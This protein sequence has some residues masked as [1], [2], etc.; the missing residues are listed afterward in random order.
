MEQY[1]IEYDT[2]AELVDKLISQKYPDQLPA[3][4]NEIR[5][6]EIQKL[7][8]K[9][10]VKIF[11][12]LNEQQLKEVNALLD[13]DGQD[14]SALKDFFA[15]AGINLEQKISEAMKEYGTAFL[16]GKND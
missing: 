16:G 6:S 11:G 4:I 8:D 5:K 7:D 10:G 1:L 2:L 12:S 14:P 13:D 15:N 3:N 9:I